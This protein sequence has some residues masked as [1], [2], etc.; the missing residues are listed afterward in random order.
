MVN[1]HKAVGGLFTF[2]VLS[3]LLLHNRTGVKV[4]VLQQ[5]PAA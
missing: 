5:K 1:L 3:Q 2:L 4:P